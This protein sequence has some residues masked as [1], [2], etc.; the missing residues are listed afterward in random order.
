MNEIELIRA[1]LSLERQHAAE[2]SRVCASAFAATDSHTADGHAS[3][4]DF[5]HAGVDY[6]IYILTRFEAREQVLR[7]LFLSHRRFAQGLNHQAADSALALTGSSREALAKLE[8]AVS[9]GSD[10]ATAA[11]WIEFLRFFTDV[12]SPRRDELDKLFEQQAKVADWRAVSGIDADSIFD[13]RRRYAH[14]RAKLPTGIEMPV[15]RSSL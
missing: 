5:R 8:I 13:E 12:W 6:L 14:W 11:Y 15:T 9:S 2:V 3:L 4:E 7:E 1:Q 10:A